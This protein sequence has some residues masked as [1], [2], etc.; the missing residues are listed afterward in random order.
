VKNIGKYII[1]TFMGLGLIYSCV[2][3]FDP[4]SENYQSLLVVEAFISDDDTAQL[5]RLSNSS[6]IDISD[7]RPESGATVVVEEVG[8]R[9]YQFIEDGSGDYWSDVSVFRPVVGN[10]YILRIQLRDG[11][12]FRSK[13]VVMKKTTPIKDI[14]FRQTEFIS[15][16]KDSREDGFEILIDTD[17][18]GDEPSY[19]RYEWDE[20]CQ[21][22]APY[23]STLDYDFEAEQIVQREDNITVCWRNRSSI[24][25]NVKS[26]EGLT[27]NEIKEHPILF[28]PF[29][30]PA[31]RERYSIEVRQYAID[32]DGYQF[33]TELKESNELTGSLFD[34]QPYPLVGNLENETNPEEPVL[35]YFD[36]ASVESARVYINNRDVPRE[37]I[38]PS[39]FSACLIESGDTAVSAFQVPEFVS[40][41]Y[42]PVRFEIG[43]GYILVFRQCADCTLRGTNVRPSF[44]EDE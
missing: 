39:L 43:Q 19:F 4:P 22:S 12:S 35:G 13:P 20:T 27:V 44:W 9:R 33:W 10:S 21:L 23:T 31:F 37:F 28:V 3:P 40:T 29:S 32:R 17:D 8:G 1:L 2:D 41:G 15:Q 14:Y 7:F 18:L 11:T 25:I 5:V 42:T 6:P 36:V 30:D 26:T 16:L 34:T 38:V 24:A